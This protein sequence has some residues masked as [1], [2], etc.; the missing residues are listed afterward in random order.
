MSISRF[1]SL[2]SCF[3]LLINT[4]YSPCLCD[5][6]YVQLATPLLIEILLN[7]KYCTMEE[8]KKSG[9]GSKNTE[10][11]EQKPLEA[12]ANDGIS[13]SMISAGSPIQSLSL[14]RNLILSFPFAST[15]TTSPLLAYVSI[16]HP[17]RGVTR[18]G[19]IRTLSPCRKGLTFSTSQLLHNHSLSQ[20]QKETQSSPS[21][22]LWTTPML[23]WFTSPH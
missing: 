17:H 14:H 20:K 11:Y 18:P 6:T 1:F 5:N 10:D 15:P 9:M 22:A 2:L 7:L 19:R 16:S 12:S 21:P 23:V 13:S 8:S 3:T 4:Q